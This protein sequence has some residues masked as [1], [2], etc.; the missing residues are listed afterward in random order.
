MQRR[1][2]PMVFAVNIRTTREM[3][4]LEMRLLALSHLLRAGVPRAK[5]MYSLESCHLGQL[6]W[7]RTALLVV[8][9]DIRHND[10]SRA[11]SLT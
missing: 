5:A 10:C 4:R 6:T 8:I 9:K 7:L 11:P 1:N 3:F 2:I